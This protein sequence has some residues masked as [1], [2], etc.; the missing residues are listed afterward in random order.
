MNRFTSLPLLVALLLCT[1]CPEKDGE[2]AKAQTPDAGAE[3]VAQVEAVV[4]QPR[5]FEDRV[6]LTG[7][8]EAVNDATL[9]AQSAG[10]VQKLVPLGTTVTR[11]GQLAR[12]DAELIAAGVQQ[13]EAQLSVA[14]SSAALA[15]DNFKRQ[16][17]LMDEGVI[18][19]LEFERI[20]AQRNQAVAMVAQ[21]QA[22]V[23][24]AHKQ[25]ANTRVLAPFTGIVEQH[26][27]EE[28][29]Q[30]NPGQPIVRITETQ[31][32]KVKAGMPERYAADIKT[33]AAIRI[34]FGAYGLEPRQGR[35]TFV[36]RTI[37]P[38]NRTFQVEAEVDNSDSVLKPGM[39]ARLLVTRTKLQDVLTVPL[40]AVVRDEVGQA[41]FL[42]DRS[43]AHPVASRRPVVTSVSSGNQVVVSEGLEPGDEVIIAGQ[44]DLTRGDRVE[45]SSDKR[46]STK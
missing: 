24:Q 15:E 40:A 38:L 37:N 34:A 26:F 22:A 29:E 2:P 36:G 1:G 30:L 35:L 12:L 44:G 16:K 32:M 28:G 41:V 33:G 42:V 45:V 27:V 14:R 21:A 23:T 8:L 25:L 5:E 4:V 19:A 11:G 31:T 39:V 6:E 10:T 20:L 46:A 7:A 3:R 18:S 9:S 13:A 43:G 17:P